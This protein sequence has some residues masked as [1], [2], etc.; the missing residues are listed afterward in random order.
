MTDNVGGGVVA[1]KSEYVQPK[2]L[3]KNI[4]LH[5]YRHMTSLLLKYQIKWS[6]G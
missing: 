4:I 6:V 2:L 3:T 5:T 1:I